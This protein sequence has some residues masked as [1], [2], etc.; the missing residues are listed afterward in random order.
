M[1]IPTIITGYYETEDSFEFSKLWYTNTKKHFPN[2]P[3]ITICVDGN[4]PAY[5]SNN[6]I[7]LSGNLGHVGDLLHGRNTYT[8]CGWSA[9]VIAG[10]MLAY[11]NETN[12]AWKEQDVLCF[13]SPQYQM[14]RQLCDGG[15]IFGASQL[16]ACA[17]SLFLI[18]HSYIPE[19]VRLY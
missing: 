15:I 6:T 18:E 7:K 10:V 9:A 17:Q 16:H 5:E 13:G 19:F 8:H 3:I 14:E 12:A 11:C 2:S 1:K 4:Y